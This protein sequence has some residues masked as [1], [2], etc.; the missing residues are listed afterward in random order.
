MPQATGIPLR[1]LV[2]TA[3]PVA[4]LLIAALLALGTAAPVSGAPGN[5]L[6]DEAEETRR[7]LERLETDIARISAAQQAREAQRSQTQAQLRDSENRL[8]SLKTTLSTLSARI[9][10]SE[11]ELQGL[12]AQAK[13]LN[14]EAQTQQS[15]VA[16]EIRRA[17]K[18]AENDQLKLLLSQEDPQAIARLLT[19][20]RYVLGA[21]NALLI[22]YSQ[23]LA[24]ISN[25]EAALEATRRQL[26]QQREAVDRQRETVAVEQAQRQALLA[27][28]TAELASDAEI[29][30]QRQQDRADL[31]ELLAEIEAAMSAVSLPMETQP[32]SE[33][34]GQMPW[35]VDGKIT[36]RYG[37]PRNQGKMRWQGVRLAAEAGTAVSAIHHGRVVYA[38]WLRGSGLL[39]VIDHGEGYMSLYAHNETLLRD[40]G[41]WVSTGAPIA[42]VGDSGGQSEAALYFEVRKDGTPTDPQRWCR[43]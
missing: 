10:D 40:V 22:E 23:I 3:P 28:I 12:D 33:A 9:A 4:A 41:D 2:Q 34:Q 14:G 31:E 7:E 6:T 18:G 42:T 37:S 11:T 36:Q 20:Y 19:Y 8:S 16:D 15:R 38:D 21:R 24:D 25:T 5:E 17:F 35:P 1:R 13:R 32:F 39:L 30:A 29:L 43:G 26:Q 27:R